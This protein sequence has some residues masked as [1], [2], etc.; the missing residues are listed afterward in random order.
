MIVTIGGLVSLLSEVLSASKIACRFPS[1][2]SCSDAVEFSLN[3]LIQKS[4]AIN[5]AV[6]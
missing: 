4:S 2:I 5:A 1:S 6:S 3:T